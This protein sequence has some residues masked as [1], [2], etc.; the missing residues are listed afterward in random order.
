MI[1]SL[2]IGVAVSCGLPLILVF[3]LFSIMLWKSES[4]QRQ[5]LLLDQARV[6]ADKFESRFD[7]AD[8]S[9]LSGE[10]QE[11]AN[12]YLNT[13]V[14]DSSSFTYLSVLDAF[15]RALCFSDDPRGN[16]VLSQADKERIYQVQEG[17]HFEDL[18]EIYI[19]LNDSGENPSILMRVGVARQ[20]IWGVP[21]AF[22]FQ[23]ILMGVLALGLAIAFSTFMVRRFLNRSLEPLM[24]SVERVAEGDFT[25][26]VDTSYVRNELMPF[27]S[28]LNR[29]F[30]TI[31][32]DKQ[33]IHQL[34]SKLTD[35]EK[36]LVSAKNDNVDR[37][38][39]MQRE[40]QH[41]DERFKAILNM[42]WQGIVV[43]DDQGKV[44]SQNPEIH[45]LIRLERRN[46]DIFIPDKIRRM[47]SRLFESDGTESVDGNFEFTDDVFLK[48]RRCRFRAQKLPAHG[49]SQQVLLVLEDSTRLDQIEKERSDF[50]ELLSQ[51]ILPVLD[52]L[53][54][55]VQGIMVLDESEREA[56]QKRLNSR[57]NYLAAVMNDWEYWDRKTRRTELPSA[58]VVDLAGIINSLGKSKLGGFSESVHIHLPDEDLNVNG[59][60]EE[61]RKL[62][63]EVYTLVQLAVPGSQD[64][65]VDLMQ[66]SESKTVIFR[67][68]PSED[69]AW[70]P[71][72]WIKRFSD[73]APLTQETWIGL[74]ISIVR[75]LAGYYGIRMTPEVTG[76]GSGRGIALILQIPIEQPKKSQDTAVDD[77]IKQFFISSA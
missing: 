63:N 48:S 18:G 74:K 20:G 75:F 58:E 13:L 36:I 42:T 26:R 31:E 30:E 29:L 43:F 12:E 22:L 15:G 37:I 49:G 68:R 69:Q 46:R 4:S 21:I 67:K 2:K 39:E 51:T 55:S 16:S 73:K 17:K 50:A 38:Q 59:A 76:E 11:A 56:G 19:P 71:P 6:I 40:V 32:G 9:L 57:V 27:T 53:V 35:F 24:N 61:Y 25:R 66:D 72:S 70:N 3:A 14:G 60:P 1:R 41:L 10:R 45:R 52:E 28:S 5:N 54:Q 23:V 44:Q 47:I 8:H 65:A 33:R 7:A 64:S 77:L 62:L 34:R